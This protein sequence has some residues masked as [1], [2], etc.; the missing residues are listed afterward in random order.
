M[1]ILRFLFVLAVLLL[2]TSLA[3]E[4][5]HA[6][7]QVHSQSGEKSADHQKD[8]VRNNE[9][10]ARPKPGD[11]A[12]E[13]PAALARSTTKARPRVSHSKPAPTYRVRSVRKPPGNSPRIEEPESIAPLEQMSSNT[14]SNIP[15]KAVSRRTPSVPSSA[16]SVNGQQFRSSRNPGAHL[17]A[18]GGPATIARGTAAI[19]GTEMKRKP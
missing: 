8:E 1:K 12:Q 6:S 7:Q 17:A 14:A 13:R 16:V 5:D 2:R 4:A 11:E 19:N 15:N 18:S 3:Q 10:Q 9:N